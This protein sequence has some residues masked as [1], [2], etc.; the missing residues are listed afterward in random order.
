[1]SVR[2]RCFIA[3]VGVA[4]L[5]ACASLG[6]P[7]AGLID[8]RLP[9][10]P[11]A[12]HC[13]SSLA[14]DADRRVEPFVLRDPA[15]DWPRL[16]DTVAAT[17]RTTLVSRDQRYAHAEVMSPWHFYTDDLELLRAPDGRVDVRSTSRVGYYDFKVNRRRVE[18]L[19][20]KLLDAGILRGG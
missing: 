1:M 4:G 11:P 15:H 16:L 19:R 14:A 13:V 8:G 17:E 2:V 20:Q 12:P 9:E 6:T 18:V 10:C 3:A 5:Q 7:A